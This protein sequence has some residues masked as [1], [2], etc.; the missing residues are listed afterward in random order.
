MLLERDDGVF[1]RL[2]NG[3]E[4]KLDL[5]PPAPLRWIATGWA[6]CGGFAIERRGDHIETYVLPEAQP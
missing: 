2:P 1:F 3:E 5:D 4:T 6:Q